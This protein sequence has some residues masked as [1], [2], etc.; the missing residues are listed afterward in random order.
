VSTD[1]A[2]I[3]TV[4]G[5]AWDRGQIKT[6]VWDFTQPLASPKKRRTGHLRMISLFV[7]GQE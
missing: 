5:K 6:M 1:P 2:N 7:A 3:K 4:S